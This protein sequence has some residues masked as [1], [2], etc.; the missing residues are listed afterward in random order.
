MITQT[1]IMFVSPNALLGGGEINQML[2]AS[3][4]DRARFV[5]EVVVSADGP[6]SD[7]L[8]ARDI[9]VKVLSIR[10]VRVGSR[11]LPSP[12]AAALLYRY[13]RKRRPHIVHSSSLPE[14]LHSS[15][16]GRMAGVPVVHDAQTIIYRAAPFDRWRAAVSAR[17]ICISHAIRNSMARARLPVHNT[18]VIYSGVD[19]AEHAR[20]D[21][22]KF[23]EEFGLADAPVVGIASRLSPEKGHDYFLRAA[24]ALKERFPNARFLVV[25]GATYA[26]RQYEMY[27]KD[28]SH[29]LGLDNCVIFTGFRRDVLNA[30]AAMDVLVCAADEE[31]LGRVV[32]E[33]M[34]LGKPVVATKAGGP[35]ETVEDGVTGMLV[36]PNDSRSLAEAIARMLE[37]PENAGQMGRR[38]RERAESSYSIEQ[39]VARV[40]EVYRIVRAQ[41]AARRAR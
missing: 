32:L 25:G 18:E 16:A 28:L 2:L 22:R 24:A 36:R 19:L 13:I 5:P 10:P 12:A 41:H 30:I 35:C 6:Y 11:K 27:L 40:Q 3:H 8:R 37:N 39:N 34:A 1:R 9:P 29:A 21:G 17:V 31:A 7:E 33:A 26:P 38:A 20:A 23:R 14:D 4:L 15:V